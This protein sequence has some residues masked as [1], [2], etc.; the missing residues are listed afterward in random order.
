MR[1]Q[2]FIDV[3]QAPD[4]S[5]FE[6]RLVRFAEDLDFGFVAA[7]LVVDRPGQSASFY[8]IGNT[9]EGFVEAQR[10]PADSRR[11][12]VLK[13][14]KRTHVPV[15]YDQ[16]LYV[17]DGAADLWEEQAPYGYRNGVSVALHLPDHKHFLLGV[18]RE[19]AL[20]RS[21]A[22]LTRLLASLQ[23]LA[24]HAQSAAQRLLGDLPETDVDPRLTPRE[25]EVLR[26]TMEGK[27]AWATGQILAVSEH[28]VNFHLRNI[29]QKLDVVTKHQ[30]VLKALGLGL[31]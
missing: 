22:V 28:T 25:L 5:T 2:Q 27:S 9:P 19:R 3:S 17:A 14:L 21:D 23:L 29:L 10:N 4:A 15:A 26:W 6:R 20:P 1:I 13:R 18:D 11:D 24:V 7:V 8:S 31:L 30:A 12:P 16:K